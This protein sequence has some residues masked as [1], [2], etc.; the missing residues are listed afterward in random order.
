MRKNNKYSCKIQWQLAVVIALLFLCSTKNSYAQPGWYTQSTNDTNYTYNSVYFYNYLTGWI[1]GT[2]G[3]IFKTTNGGFNWT[4]Q[5]TN[6]YQ[7]YFQKINGVSTSDQYVYACGFVNNSIPASA[8]IQETSNGGTIWTNKVINFLNFKNLHFINP[9]T[10]F[11]IGGRAGTLD[12]GRIYRTTNAGTGGGNT[13][14]TSYADNSVLTLG[15]FKAITFINTNTGWISA[16][17]SQ[18]NTSLLKTTNMGVNWNITGSLIPGVFINDIKFINEQTGWAC[19]GGAAG[20]RAKVLKTTNGGVNWTEQTFVNSNM[21]NSMS[22]VQ[23]FNPGLTY[24]GFMVGENGLV[25]ISYDMGETWIQQITPKLNNLNGVYFVDGKVGWAVGNNANILATYN[26]GVQVNNI[27]T[28]VPEQYK[29][30]QNYPNPFNP[31]TTIKFD[32]VK[33]G[34]VNMA[35]F[36]GLGRKIETLVNE[37]L[38]PGTYSATWDAKALP[39]GVYFYRITAQ[40]YTKTMKMSLVK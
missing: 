24:R 19:G 16:T 15:I 23:Y 13:V 11:V 10:G 29:V 7:N 40:N 8:T 9:F 33:S 5:L 28:N 36:D 25:Y 22:W 21:F 37:E 35:I 27:S 14:Y 6:S 31:V 1:C 4:Q 39:S 34:F 2:N 26:G 30:Y 17:N 32:V 12:T 38:K 3:K 18:N 20:N